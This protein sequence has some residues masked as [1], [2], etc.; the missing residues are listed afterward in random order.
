MLGIFF[1]GVGVACIL[2]ALSWSVWSLAAGLT[3]IGV[4]AAIYHPVGTAMLIAAIG[5]FAELAMVLKPGG[6]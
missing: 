6:T 4:F 2:T 1:C 3:L 5:A